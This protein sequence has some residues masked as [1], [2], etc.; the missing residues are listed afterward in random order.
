MVVSFGGWATKY[1]QVRY[2]NFSW[3]ESEIDDV[4]SINPGFL[5]V[6]IQSRLHKQREVSKHASGQTSLVFNK[7]GR[8]G[9]GRGV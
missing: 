8:E 7:G 9:G 4:M 6:I 1:M 2:A 3:F 5:S